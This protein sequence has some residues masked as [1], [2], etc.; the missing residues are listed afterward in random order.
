[1]LTLITIDY[2]SQNSLSLFR[3][4]LYSNNNNNN[5]YVLKV[6]L[7]T[8]W[9]NTVRKLS[10]LLPEDGGLY[11]EKI[12]RYFLAMVIFV[13][14]HSISLASY[15]ASLVTIMSLLTNTISPP[16]CRV[17]SFLDGGL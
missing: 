14:I 7:S 3:L 12:I 11:M 1:M 13:Q 4:E 6:A 8:V 15:S 5:N 17:L 9:C 2:E 16:P 10:R